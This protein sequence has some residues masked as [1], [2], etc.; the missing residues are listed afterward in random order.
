M[1][2]VEL[3]VVKLLVGQPLLDALDDRAEHWDVFVDE[4]AEI[5]VVAVVVDAVVA[6]FQKARAFHSDGLAAFRALRLQDHRPSEKDFAACIEC[7]MELEG[8]AIN[9]AVEVLEALN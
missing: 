6:H 3:A 1:P 2:D 4:G 7:L 8:A 5:E 9:F